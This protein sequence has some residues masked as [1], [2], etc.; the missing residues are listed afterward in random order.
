[1]KKLAALLLTGLMTLSFGACQKTENTNA[2]NASGKPV[3]SAMKGEELDPIM[4]DAK[5]KEEYLVLDVRSE[6]EYKEGHVKFAINL[7]VET[8]DKNLALIEGYKDKNVVTICNTGKKSQKAADLLIEKGFK[9]VFNAQ[10]VKDFKYTTMTKVTNVLGS[11]LQ[12]IADEGKMT[13][14]DVRD[15]K[16]YEAGHLKGAINIPVDQVDAKMST[17]AKD[18]PVIFYCYTGNK[19]FAAA[20]KFAEKGYETYNSLDGTK[21]FGFKMAK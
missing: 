6:K 9:K 19:S 14:V 7:D 12:K 2:S 8:L 15:A 4:E 21:E 16:D 10:G 11:Q 20:T 1:M 13:I 18:K 17:I 3:V 5:K